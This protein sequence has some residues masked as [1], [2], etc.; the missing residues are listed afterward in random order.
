MPTTSPI[1]ITA[2]AARANSAASLATFS[3][4][5]TRT[6]W[7]G[8]PPCWTQ[9]TGVSGAG[10]PP[11]GRR[12]WPAARDRHQQHEGGS[13]GAEARPVDGRA[14][15]PRRE[16]AGGD[17]EL[18]RQPAVRQRDSGQPGH[19]DGGADARHHRAFDARLGA[20]EQL[21]AAAPED[22]RVAALEPHHALARTG[23]LD[24]QGD[25]VLLLGGRPSQGSCR[26]R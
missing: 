24:E 17:D 18:L 5:L 20:A 4:E 1:T 6:R 14:G 3:S 10:R 8:V 19:G 15:M 21:L 11:A 26:R 13:A 2:G 16:M 12:R 23:S 7:A 9:A 22:E 25:D